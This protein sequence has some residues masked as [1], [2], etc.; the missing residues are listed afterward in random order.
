MIITTTFCGTAS[1][2]W[3]TYSHVAKYW[4]GVVAVIKLNWGGSSARDGGWA[5]VVNVPML[6]GLQGATP[7][8]LYAAILTTYDVSPKKEEKKV[9]KLKKFK[10]KS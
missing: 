6:E 10:K 9:K 7:N 8:A 5:A 4:S 3:F 2:F 1:L